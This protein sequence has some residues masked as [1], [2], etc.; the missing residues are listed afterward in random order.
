M[1]NSTTNGRE[2]NL[3]DNICFLVWF[4]RFPTLGLIPIN[5]VDHVRPNKGGPKTL[6]GFAIN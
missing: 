1:Y 3:K 5:N 2:T 6:K 4:I